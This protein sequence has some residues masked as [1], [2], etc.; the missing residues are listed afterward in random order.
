MA[1]NEAPVS[2]LSIVGALVLDVSHQR[3]SWLGLA[4]A[5]CRFLSGG[6]L[7][8]TTTAHKRYRVQREASSAMNALLMDNLQGIRQITQFSRQSHEDTRFAQRADLIGRW[9]ALNPSCAPGQITVP[10]CNSSARSA[11]HS[12][13]GS[14]ACGSSTAKMQVGQLIAFMLYAGMFFYEPIGRLHA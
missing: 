8:Y 4:R 11:P 12:C 13:C 7:W 9:L 6:A 5:R 3:D 1:L 14:A 2:L 10:R